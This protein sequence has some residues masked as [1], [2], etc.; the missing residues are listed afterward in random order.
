MSNTVCNNQTSGC[1]KHHDPTLG[2][3]SL[4]IS[5]CEQT[6]ISALYC[7]T[8]CLSLLNFLTLAALAQP[9]PW[10]LPNFAD[11]L[12]LRVANATNHTVE[13]LAVVPVAEAAR[14]AAGFPGTLAIVTDPSRGRSVL[15]SQADDLDGDGIPDEFVFPVHLG[16]HETRPVHIY[17]STTLRE[18]LPWPKRVHASHA[19]GYNRSTVALESE[20]IGYRTYGGF[21]LDI[22]ARREGKPGL[23]NSL[24]GYL[25]SGSP[26]EVGMDVIHLGD[27]LGFGGLFLRAGGDV[28]RPPVN[29]PDYAHKPAPAEA[30]EY[31]VIADG[32][33]RA[34]VEARMERW[35]IGPDEVDIRAW[36]SIAA[37][38]DSVEC[39]FRILPLKLCRTYEVGAGIRHLP[40]MKLD[41]APGRLALA[42][43]QTAQIGPLGMALY[44]DTAAAEARDPVA[45]KDD[46]NECVVFRERLDPGAAVS[47]RYRVAAAWSGTGIRTCCGTW[48]LWRRRRAP[49]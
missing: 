35:T 27:T 9:A 12:E 1:E 18:P 49:P 39:R 2:N 22:Q 32:P 41:A 44:Y 3:Q 16:P 11:R 37:G 20:C 5:S 36:Y 15:P 46:V 31:R 40:K 28:Y 6:L 19:F 38:E 7:L 23:Y 34:V 21:F 43:R 8:R 33:V 17:Y 45:T 30:P 25:G 13:T 48:P 14:T 47:G 29:M 10:L 24:V 26:S 42:G 4:Q